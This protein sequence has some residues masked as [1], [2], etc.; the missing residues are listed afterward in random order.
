LVTAEP[1][2]HVGDVVAAA[3][4]YAQR[5]GFSVAFIY[6]DPPFYAQVRRDGARLNLRHVDAPV[7][8]PDRRDA[9]QLLSA[10]I[11][12][13]DARALAH[14]YERAGVAFAQALR[15]EPWGAETFI[16]RDPDGN[17]VLFASAAE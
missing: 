12:L 1:Q 10:T 16:V 11:V 7:V 5:L 15:T 8:D 14:E 4:F 17:L 3:E 2:L 9:E 6:G 13:D